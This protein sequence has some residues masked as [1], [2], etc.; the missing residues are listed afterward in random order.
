MGDEVPI[1]CLDGAL[2]FLGE[3]EDHIRDL[4]VES[5]Q[6]A[7]GDL[8]PYGLLVA[9][10]ASRAILLSKGFRTLM[11]DRNYVAAYL[12][13]RLAMDCCL[14]LVAGDFVDDLHDYANHVVGG[15]KLSSY[16]SNDGDQF[17]DA[18]FAQQAPR[19][20]PK[21]QCQRHVRA[22]FIVDTHEFK[23]RSL[24]NA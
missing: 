2:A 24:G 10:A 12:L 1:R 17:R 22:V 21:S 4:G 6:A 3:S 19:K 8:Y 9:S 23:A 20:V 5:L 11:K 7:D 13:V 14:C 15:G 16:K 18:F